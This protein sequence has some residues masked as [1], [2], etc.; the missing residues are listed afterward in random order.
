MHEPHRP[1][2]LSH[3]SA[4]RCLCIPKALSHLGC[5]SPLW[6]WQ[7]SLLLK[8]SSPTALVTAKG[9]QRGCALKRED[10]QGM[11]LAGG[12]LCSADQSSKAQ[13]LIPVCRFP[14]WGHGAVSF[15]I[16]IN[17][18]RCFFL[19]KAWGGGERENT[20]ASFAPFG[21]PSALTSPEQLPNTELSFLWIR[22][23]P[24][25]KNPLPP[26]RLLPAPCS[27]TCMWRGAGGE[28]PPNGAA[29]TQALPS[30]L[31]WTA[32]SQPH[33][34][35]VLGSASWHRCHSRH[36]ALC[37]PSNPETSWQPGQAAAS[38]ASPACYR[39]GLSRPSVLSSLSRGWHCYPKCMS[40]RGPI[41]IF[42]RKQ[43]EILLGTIF[44]CQNAVLWAASSTGFF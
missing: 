32:P 39:L 36:P 27:H 21:N 12:L 19:A 2:P 40:L 13:R 3:L 1:R 41:N 42:L 24:R 10:S 30:S 5:S 29:L 17:F 38:S 44:F 4:Q 7:S 35:F 11:G 9:P 14:S 18:H 37:F 23:G 31:G 25:L 8:E 22:P 43:I 33:Q 26:P 16:P 20:R 15:S 28:V 34:V 6:R